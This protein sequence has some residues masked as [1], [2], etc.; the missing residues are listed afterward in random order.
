MW[1][2]CARLILSG[3]QRQNVAS[4]PSIVII[5]ALPFSRAVEV[6]AANEYCFR[7]CCEVEYKEYWN[8]EFFVETEEPVGY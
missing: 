4:P 8:E 6:F 1:R 5:A 3:I 7:T 2:V